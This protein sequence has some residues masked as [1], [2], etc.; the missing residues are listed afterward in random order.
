MQSHGKDLNDKRLRGELPLQFELKGV[1][2]TAYELYRLLSDKLIV[3][4]Y[5]QE[6]S[7][8]NEYQI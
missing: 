2:S 7:V 1:K 8:L 5:H 6:R 4:L 3:V